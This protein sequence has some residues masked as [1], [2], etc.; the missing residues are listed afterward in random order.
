M[1]EA[2]EVSHVEI[3]GTMARTAR[4]EPIIELAEWDLPIQERHLSDV[5]E[6]GVEL[7]SREDPA[8]PA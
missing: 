8:E 7:A 2:G 4:D 3:L 1:A 5:R 6:G